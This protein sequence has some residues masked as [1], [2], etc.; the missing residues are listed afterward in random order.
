MGMDVDRATDAASVAVCIPTFRRAADL[1]RLLATLPEVIGEARLSGRLGEVVVIV[2]DNDEGES[3]RETVGE[4]GMPVR[5]VVESERGV[6]AVRNRALD[7]ATRHDLLVFIDDDE[8]PA[9]PQWLA[10]LLATREEFDAA[11]VAGPVRTVTDEPLDP[12]IVAG[13]FFARAHRVGL[14]TGTRIDR[15][16]T[17]NLLLDLRVVEQAGIRFDPRFGRTGG[18]DSLF[19]AQLHA[20]GAHMVWCAEAG[21]LDHLPVDRR[22]RAHAL[23]RTRGMANAGVRVA[24]ALADSPMRRLVVRCK[25]LA[26]GVLRWILGAVRGIAGRLVRSEQMRA[27]GA[28]ERA[29]GR[30]SISGAGNR[31]RDLYGGGGVR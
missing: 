6:V 18:E 10:L 19:T 23:E 3:A 13:G 28:K 27:T 21:V 9:D 12:W 7:E 22:T 24:L 20:T 5:Y 1:S 15:A 14:A 2:I 30:G 31:T 11:V 29:R 16:A 4:A 26:A 17:N 25:A 8:T